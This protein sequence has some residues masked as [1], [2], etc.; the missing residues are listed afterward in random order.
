MGNVDE[1]KSRTIVRRRL[2]RQRKEVETEVRHLNALLDPLREVQEGPDA[3]ALTVS[4][5]SVEND[6]L[7]HVSLLQELRSMNAL[8]SA[9]WDELD[10]GAI[11]AAGATLPPLTKG[12][13]QAMESVFD[14][15][16]AKEELITWAWEVLALASKSY[17]LA[18]DQ[19]IVAKKV[20]QTGE[21]VGTVGLRQ[22]QSSPRPCPDP[23]SC[24]HG[25]FE[26]V[27]SRNAHLMGQPFAAGL[28]AAHAAAAERHQQAA[29]DVWQ[30]MWCHIVCTQALIEIDPAERA[31]MER[32]ASDWRGL[33]QDIWAEYRY[34]LQ[35]WQQQH[36]TLQE[37][38]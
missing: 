22:R 36:V 32:Y 27:F 20:L 23:A 29:E 18:M 34:E 4:I 10:P 26:C 38:S 37:Q 28:C 33:A 31:D 7:W 2:H 35:V 13:V 9:S 24:T 25:R 11:P 17:S 30:K 19:L 15:L 16:R 3:P 6:E 12:R 14:A 21:F 5:G 1:N 8:H